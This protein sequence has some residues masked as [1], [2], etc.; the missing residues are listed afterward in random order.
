[1]SRKTFVMFAALFAAVFA[2]S[3]RDDDKL[4]LSGRVKEAA[5]RNDLT[6]A[7]VLLYDSAGNVTDSIRA[8]RGRT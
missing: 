4:T 5:G 7:Y 2:L 6:N 1:M 8:N 3:A